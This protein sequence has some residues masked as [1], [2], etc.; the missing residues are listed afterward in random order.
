MAKKEMSFER[1]FANIDYIAE[2]SEVSKKTEEKNTKIQNDVNTNLQINKD[3]NLQIN[4]VTSLQKPK[5]KSKNK[6]VLSTK[7]IADK[8]SQGKTEGVKNVQVMASIDFK[9]A[10]KSYCIINAMKEHE[11]I[12]SAIQSVFNGDELNLQYDYNDNGK[13]LS[14]MVYGKFNSNFKKEVLLYCNN[15]AITES[16]LVGCAVAKMICWKK[17]KKN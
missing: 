6:T 12:Y 7:K 16:Q 8:T 14:K 17:T 15:N 13:D 5:A 1:L 9:K 3:T 2:Q 11:L 4:K 10:V